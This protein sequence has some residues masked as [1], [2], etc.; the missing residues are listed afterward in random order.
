MFVAE[1]LVFTELHKTG[2]THICKWLERLV[3]GEHVGKHN[4]VPKRLRNRFV[5]GSIRNPWDWYVSLWAYGCSGRGSVYFQ[6]T[7][8]LSLRYLNEQLGPEMGFD[9]LPLQYKLRQ[10]L[11]D[12]RRPIHSWREVYSSAD[13][14]HAFRRWLQLI[15]SYDRRFDV[16]EGYG[17][18]PSAR[19]AGLM[20]YRYL[21]LFTGLG[22]RLYLDRATETVDG[23]RHTIETDAV[24]DFVIRNEHLEDD[25]LVAVSRAGYAI[26][27]KE[28]R[29]FLAQSSRSKTNTS[30]RMPTASYYDEPSARLVEE[31]EELIVSAFG[32]QAP[33]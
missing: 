12:L 32:Y 11:A 27:E 1:K 7:R 14:V 29:E 13:D 8:G 5:V 30:T 21:K 2:G 15:M 10:A 4:R 28:R 19:W 6:T 33:I 25:L 9:T 16:A 24:V 3:G 17:F 18:S 31:R 23:A 22:E 26:D 20:S